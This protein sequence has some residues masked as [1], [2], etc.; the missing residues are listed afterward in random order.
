LLQVLLPE[1]L[2]S[3]HAAGLA[4]VVLH[5]ALGETAIPLEAHGRMQVVPAG[6]YRIAVTG[7]FARATSSTIEVTP[8]AVVRCRLTDQD[9]FYYAVDQFAV[10]LGRSFSQASGL[11]WLRLVEGPSRTPPQVPYRILATTNGDLVIELDG[12]PRP[13]MA[14]EILSVGHSRVLLTLAP[15]YAQRD[16]KTRALV[17]L[18]RVGTT[19]TLSARDVDPQLSQASRSISQGRADEAINSLVPFVLRYSDRGV[20]NHVEAATVG[21]ILVRTGNLDLMSAWI[22]DLV[23]GGD[24]LS[25]CLILA[26]EWYANAGC[27]L[28][29]INLLARVPMTGL[30]LLS[31]CYALAK[32][33]LVAYAAVEPG[34]TR[35]SGRGEKRVPIDVHGSTHT[36]PSFESAVALPR[37]RGQELEAWNVADAYRISTYIT[38][39][40][41]RVDWS[42]QFLK[43]ELEASDDSVGTVRLAAKHFV[44]TR[45][46]GDWIPL[47]WGLS[48]R[49]RGSSS[50]RARVLEATEEVSSWQKTQ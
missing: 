9:F 48:P 23:A 33:R 43:V 45:L 16:G 1:A 21:Y 20:S 7:P 11:I 4:S 15:R 42:E 2:H 6:V 37:V 35:R 29:A 3:Q 27:H 34:P 31:G 17:S 41:S 30:P 46:Q 47:A 12:A 8:E 22:D 24:R 25:D 14:L 26:A 19:A 10:S 32:A 5:D 39:G 44:L 18:R 49:F 28:A 40:I 36:S 38:Q 13:S 50:P